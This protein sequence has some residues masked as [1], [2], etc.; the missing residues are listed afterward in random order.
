MS[1]RQEFLAEI[2]RDLMARLEELT[3]RTTRRVE[4][5]A[6]TPV[7]NILSELMEEHS[8]TK[9]DG[10]QLDA[11][12]ESMTNKFKAMKTA[13]KKKKLR[14]SIGTYR[15]GMST[16]ENVSEYYREQQSIEEEIKSKI[17]EER[18]RLP[19]NARAL[20]PLKAAPAYI[21]KEDKFSG[22]GTIDENEKAYRKFRILFFQIANRKGWDMEEDLN[23]IQNQECYLLWIESLIPC[24][25]AYHFAIACSR[26]G[27]G[28]H[29]IASFDE[30]YDPQDPKI[31]SELET[32][33]V[34]MQVDDYDT[35][36]RYLQQFGY[37]V[38]E[39]TMRAARPNSL[40]LARHLCRHLEKSTKYHAQF[41]DVT[42]K[43]LEE[44]IG[45]ENALLCINN[46]I[47]TIRYKSGVRTNQPK[48]TK[49]PYIAHTATVT[50]PPPI[51][52][53]KLNITCGNCGMKHAGP[54]DIARETWTPENLKQA[55]WAPG[56]GKEDDP[57]KSNWWVEKYGSKDRPFF[58]Q[59]LL[60][61]KAAGA[62]THP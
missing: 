12:I 62:L 14:T 32:T 28:Q 22:D 26:P 13:R 21:M 29:V 41:N 11:M 39:L 58:D 49:S 18:R 35:L 38:Q 5:G 43:I 27:D 56:G 36:E 60:A 31:I 47:R 8:H 34:Y 25:P 37:Y 52:R 6:E 51:Q 53:S 57:K 20:P 54:K 19:T 16:A 24:S 2:R 3:P 17:E 30:K 48:N 45:Y 9:M 61:A 4:R 15:H 42:N 10:T 55:C 40:N 46:R 59:K 44:S 33:L 23:A 1:D 7:R 50:N